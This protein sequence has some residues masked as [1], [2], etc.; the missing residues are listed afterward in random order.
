MPELPEVE[1]VKNGINEWMSPQDVITK[2]KLI[3]GDFR[4]KVKERD[5][6]P[7]IGESFNLVNRRAK[8]LLFFSQK[9]VLLSH[10]GMTG[11]WRKVEEGAFQKQIKHDH[12]WIQFQSGTRWIFND[13]RRFGVL[14]LLKRDHVSQDRA[15]MELGPEPL[16]PHFNPQYCQ[17]QAYDK[18]VAIKIWLMNQKNVVG[19][20]NIYASEVLFRARVHPAIPAGKVQNKDWKQIVWWSKSILQEAIDHGG[21]TLRDYRQA[22]GDPGAHQQHL[23]VYDQDGHPC[24]NCGSE[25]RSQVLGGRSTFW[26]PV[27]QKDTCLSERN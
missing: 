7:L 27:C 20:G 5:F 17:E 12:F 22:S 4:R 14:D 21:T 15:L 8:Y 3:C 10:L 26:C 19:I 1:T 18:K 16:D 6:K 24:L 25:I 13:P 9:H 11:S 23:L 2:V